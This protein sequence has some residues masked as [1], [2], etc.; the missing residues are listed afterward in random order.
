MTTDT[1]GSVRRKRGEPRR[2][3]L[4]AAE[5]VFSERGYDASTRE[6]ADRA[7]VS[8][9]LMFRYFGSKAGLF[10]AAMVAPFVEFVDHFVDQAAPIAE[11]DGKD[12]YGVTEKFVGEL[13]DLFTEHRGLV[14]MLWSAQAHSESELAE[15]GLF[16]DVWAALDKLAALGARARSSRSA[17]NEIATRAI[18]SMI[19]GMAIAGASFRD[20][21]VPQR[22]AV[23]EEL[24]KIAYHGRAIEPH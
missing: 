3:L 22:S 2:L 20:R 14:A 10:H 17:R 9:T 18:V 12:L 16:E 7:A 21:K 8:E 15:Q 19:A 23:V 1:K 13:Y 24:A 5:Q 6:I 4:E 11:A